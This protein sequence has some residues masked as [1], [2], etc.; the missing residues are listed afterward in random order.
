MGWWKVNNLTKKGQGG[1]IDK[2]YCKNSLAGPAGGLVIGS[3][4]RCRRTTVKWI[5]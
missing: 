5:C 3:T 2:F 4:E 1:G